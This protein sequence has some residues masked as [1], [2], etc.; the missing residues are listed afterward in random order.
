MKIRVATICRSWVD[1]T[2]GTEVSH[3]LSLIFQNTSF[4]K[5]VISVHKPMCP[6]DI[7]AEGAFRLNFCMLFVTFLMAHL[8]HSIFH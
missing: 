7:L 4:K 8:Y 2:N 3:G 6:D 1:S 5:N